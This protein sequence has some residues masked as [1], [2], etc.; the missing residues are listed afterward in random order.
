MPEKTHVCVARIKAS[1]F[2]PFTSS[3]RG[4]VYDVHDGSL[5]EVRS[6]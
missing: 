6:D 4:F 3:V 1:P 5:R 2:I